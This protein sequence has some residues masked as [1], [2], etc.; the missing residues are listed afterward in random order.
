MARDRVVITESDIRVV[1]REP[2]SQGV[3][4]W[5]DAQ[6]KAERAGNTVNDVTKRVVKGVSDIVV[7][8]LS[9]CEDGE[10]GVLGPRVVAWWEQV[11]EPCWEMG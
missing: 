8:M 10:A 5:I 4:R 7:T 6:R 11:D 1:L 2:V 9:T 3:S